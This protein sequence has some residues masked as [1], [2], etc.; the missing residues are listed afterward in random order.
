MSHKRPFHGRNKQAK[1]AYAMPAPPASAPAGTLEVDPS[2]FSPV[3]GQLF[4]LELLL[5][6]AEPGGPGTRVD[7][8]TPKL[9]ISSTAVAQ[10]DLDE[11]IAGG[12]IGDVLLQRV[13]V[14][15]LRR[16]AEGEAVQFAAMQRNVNER[17]VTM[18]YWS[19]EML[20]TFHKF[21]HFF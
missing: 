6:G 8:T 19:D 10:G 13:L 17:G 11:Q 2:Q 7:H 16:I 15:V 20:E 9:D 14:E 3:M 4:D 5:F 18:H 12:V 21:F 1:N